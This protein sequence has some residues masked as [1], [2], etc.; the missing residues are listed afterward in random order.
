MP[1][2]VLIIEDSK[3]FSSMV[4]HLV[5]GTHGFETDIANSLAAANKLLYENKEQYFVSIVD[6]HLPD[7]PNGE[8][9]DLVKNNDIP[10]VVLTGTNNAHAEE[11]LWAKGIADYA[12]KSGK[13]SLEYVVWVVDRIYKNSSTKVVVVDD[14]PV[15]RAAME[16]LLHIQHYQ[17]LSA[18]SAEEALEILKRTSDIK[19]F[20]ID[21]YMEGMDGF[22]LAAQIRESHSKDSL[23]IIGVSSQG[24]Q[25]VST[26]FIKSGADD[27]LLKPFS[28]EEFFCRVNNNVSAIESFQKLKQLNQENKHL[29]G[30]AAH[31]IRGPL[32]VIYKSAQL[33]RS[34]RCDEET[35]QKF[36]SMIENNSADLLTLLDNLLN[37]SA[38]ETGKLTI[39]LKQHKLK[40]IVEERISLYQMDADAK[41][42]EIELNTDFDQETNFDETKIKQVVDNLITNAIKYSPKNGAIHIDINHKGKDII[43]RIQ[44]SGPGIKKEEQHNLFKPFSVLSSKTTGGEKSVGLGLVISKKIIDAHKGAIAYTDAENGGSCF[45]FS[46]PAA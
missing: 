27:F 8:A 2:K 39:D 5:E 25:A 12:H 26:Q 44:D 3:S 43:C 40:E 32:G 38:I 19:L 15:A 21:C 42:I 6:L 13:H 28:P 24:G 20:L 41:G 11:D 1:K 33:V 17:V 30:T 31:D 4:K 10:A 18:N 9:V 16:R 37:V 35:K 14:S 23:A 45:Y 29:L 46:L 7:A 22:E 34:D 36:L